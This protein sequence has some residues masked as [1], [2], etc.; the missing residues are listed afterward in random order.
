MKSIHQVP[1]LRYACKKDIKKMHE[2]LETVLQRIGF[3]GRGQAASKGINSS[4]ERIFRRTYL[5]RR[6]VELL[7]TV[8]LKIDSQ[9]EK[10][11]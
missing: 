5:T 8:F 11:A 9:L 6:E 1:T 10:G 4:I 2:Y 7:K 3:N